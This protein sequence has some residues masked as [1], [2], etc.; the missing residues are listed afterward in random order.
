MA[1]RTPFP[2]RLVTPEGVQFD[3]DVQMVIATGVGGEVGILA[4]HAPIVADLKMGTC[5]VQTPQG[6]W[7]VWATAE[8]FATA[9]DSTAMVLVEEAVPADAIDLAA[10]DELIADHENRIAGAGAGETEHD[11]Y[12]SDV[13]AA[14]KSVAWGE[15]LKR[16][17]EEYSAA[18]ANA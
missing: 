15:H 18:G 6:D 1:D 16:V 4:R 13:N 3:G 12:S 2:M 8:G 9:H 10:A 5:R 11:V 14:A 17:H 7:R